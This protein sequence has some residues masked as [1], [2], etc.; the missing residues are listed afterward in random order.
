MHQLISDNLIWSVACWWLP[1]GREMTTSS[2]VAMKQLQHLTLLFINLERSIAFEE[3]DHS[4]SRDNDD[5]KESDDVTIGAALIDLT[6]SLPSLVDLMVN[7]AKHEFYPPHVIHLPNGLARPLPYLPSYTNKMDNNDDNMVEIQQSGHAHMRD[8]TQL[9][10]W[11]FPSLQRLSL[12]NLGG[13]LPMIEAPLLKYLYVADWYPPNLTLDD[14]TEKESETKDKTKEM[15]NNNE[16]NELLKQQQKMTSQD[17]YASSQLWFGCSSIN[18]LNLVV[19]HDSMS[20]LRHFVTRPWLSLTN[21]PSSSLSLFKGIHTIDL[22][23]SSWYT[24]EIKTMLETWPQLTRT[25]L[26]VRHS[27]PPTL[28]PAL[29]CA[30]PGLLSIVVK[31][32]TSVGT[33]D[34]DPNANTAFVI[35]R[36]SSS[37]LSLTDG[38]ESH[39]ALRHLEITRVDTS[40]LCNWTFPVLSCLSLGPSS[41]VNRD[42]VASHV[43]P[44]M[45][46]LPMIARLEYH[47]TSI[48]PR[49]NSVDMN[50]RPPPPIPLPLRQPTD[51][52]A[53]SN[54]ATLPTP[55][56]PVAAASGMGEIKSMSVA[57]S[58]TSSSILPILTSPTPI[59]SPWPNEP[60][61]ETTLKK[62]TRL[63]QFHRLHTLA[64]EVTAG[65]CTELVASLI[66]CAAPTL[67]DL[68]LFGCDQ[69]ILHRVVQVIGAVP[70]LSNGLQSMYIDS[71][72]AWPF[73]QFAD[74]SQRLFNN[75]HAL[76]ILSVPRDVVDH[77]LDHYRT[78]RKLQ[79]TLPITMETKQRP[80]ISIISNDDVV[81]QT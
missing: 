69:S 28:I 38:L 18:E 81:Q 14:L 71:I 49:L 54:G 45:T 26:H 8:H 42:D 10:V 19:A 57:M 51:G 30:C 34:D 60:T 59:S 78:W 32:F 77:M 27:M 7:I 61:T 53:S 58:V 17:R 62:P 64:L 39:S 21:A 48:L 68:T 9:H 79:Q 23:I 15:N 72:E 37:S 65:V 43:L 5:V 41:F 29:L 20:S 25:T 70:A 3:E 47:F 36:P 22:D 1:I 13:V 67:M 35:K 55:V 76:V 11:R 80:Y 74:L 6:Q 31:W 40:L 50:M 75:C 56:P 16:E 73:D 63:L 44:F 66:T 24:I 46:R 33:I 4:R 2:L 12:Q 52:A